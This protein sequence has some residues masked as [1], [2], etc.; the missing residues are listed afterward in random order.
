MKK[1]T[2]SR[3]N[4]KNHKE[5]KLIVWAAISIAAALFVVFLV[6]PLLAEWNTQQEEIAKITK[7]LPELR[8]EE[9]KA[10]EHLRE[11]ENE[12]TRKVEPFKIEE[13]KLLPKDINVAI[14]SKVLELYAEQISTIENSLFEITS[15]SFG[16][17][18]EDENSN[19][20]IT[21]ISLQ[22]NC[23]EKMLRDFVFQLQRGDIVSPLRE[24]HE[25]GL[26]DP[27]AFKFV[28]KHGFPLSQIDAIDSSSESLE[29]G[30]ETLNVSL[31][32]RAY[33]RK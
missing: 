7:Q 29:G 31:S 30:G 10:Q 14:Y 22:F 2:F 9:E 13:E 20:R 5:P 15:L 32:I 23:T 28:E 4:V 25:V 11:I 19:Y 24:A 18:S 21:D 17:T 6:I 12:F 26:T 16:R 27:K 33:S 3:S 8:S 1:S